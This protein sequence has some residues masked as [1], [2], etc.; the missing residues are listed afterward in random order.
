MLYLMSLGTVLYNHIYMFYKCKK[1]C[2]DM[3]TMVINNIDSHSLGNSNCAD[4]QS[5]SAFC[6][7]IKPPP[8]Y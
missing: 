6:Y 8:N 2:S 4:A 5:D 7:F 1:T 3:H